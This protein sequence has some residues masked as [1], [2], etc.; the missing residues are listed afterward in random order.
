MAQVC[1][2]II[3]KRTVRGCAGQSECPEH[4]SNE[5]HQ[6]D[7]YTLHITYWFQGAAG[8][9]CIENVSKSIVSKHT[10]DQERKP[11]IQVFF[12][13]CRI[14]IGFSITVMGK[15][16]LESAFMHIHFLLLLFNTINACYTKMHQLLMK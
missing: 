13:K 12:V 5:K 11:I 9:R 10:N 8:T 6:E 15:E 14:L 3:L 1:L 4:C 16:F 2:L 7:A